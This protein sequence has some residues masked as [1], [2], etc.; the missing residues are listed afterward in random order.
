L[1]SAKLLCPVVM[2]AYNPCCSKCGT[3]RLT[4]LHEAMAKV[5]DRCYMYVGMF[6]VQS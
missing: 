5:Q 1:H 6:H 2:A 4:F 3:P